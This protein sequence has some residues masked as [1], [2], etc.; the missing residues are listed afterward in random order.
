MIQRLQSLYLFLAAAAMVSV[1]LVSTAW[2][3]VDDNKFYTLSLLSVE[4]NGV[5]PYSNLLHFLPFSVALL[6]L[7]HVV[8]AFFSFRNLKKQ[9]RLTLWAMFDV[10]LY[11]GALAYCIR[12]MMNELQ[13]GF[14]PNLGAV[15]PAVAFVLCILAWRGIQRDYQLLRSVDRI[16]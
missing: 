3:N 6:V 12:D 2:F 1:F 8:W 5:E 7:F 15:L 11:Y 10:V 13:V 14:T 4:A 16:R 9:R